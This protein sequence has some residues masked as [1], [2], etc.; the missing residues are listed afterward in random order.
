VGN[1]PN[2]SADNLSKLIKFT[3]LGNLI[4]I[5]KPNKH[6]KH[7]KLTSLSVSTETTSKAL[8]LL[9]ST[10]KETTAFGNVFHLAWVKKRIRKNI[11]IERHS[12]SQK[13]WLFM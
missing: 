12:C 7:T 13:V 5:T 8:G 9:Q 3:K 4:K 10:E 6:A 11:A 1:V 2:Q